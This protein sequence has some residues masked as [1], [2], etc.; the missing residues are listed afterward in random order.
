MGILKVYNSN[1][2]ISY[3]IIPS[4]DVFFTA[5]FKLVNNVFQIFPT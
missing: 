4:Q 5:A 3:I 2:Y 1:I